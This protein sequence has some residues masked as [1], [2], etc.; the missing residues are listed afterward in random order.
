MLD[1]Q[2]ICDHRDEVVENCK[3]AVCRPMWML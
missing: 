1:L 2:F 3:N